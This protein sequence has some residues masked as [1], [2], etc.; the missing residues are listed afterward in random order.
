MISTLLT[1]AAATAI[2]TYI[3][4]ILEKKAG[5]VAP[6]VHKP[7]KP[8]I[9]KT[10]GPA[11]MLSFIIGYIIVCILVKDV[12]NY[13][14][15][16][17][18]AI[19]IGGI[20]GLIDDFTSL[21][22]IVKFALAALPAIPVIIFGAYSPYP[23]VPGIGVLRITL[24]YPVA[25]LLAYSVG[26]NG[27]NMSDTHNGLVP[28]IMG[29]YLMAI[30]MMTVYFSNRSVD[31]F[32]YLYIISAGLVLGYLWFNLYPAKIFNGNA[33]SYMFGTMLVSLA[34]TSRLEFF[35]ILALAPFFL[36]GF[37]ILTSIKG[38]RNKE[39]LR[40]R[41]TVVTDDG[42]IKAN[43]SEEAPITLV[44]LL[45]LKRCLK[46]PELIASYNLLYILSFILAAATYILL[47]TFV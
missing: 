37:N 21:N 8:L 18:A 29:F 16:H 6:D 7:D 30:G 13:V 47:D 19:L 20:I 43:V 26:G 28:T 22:A 1:I 32:P 9:P 25:L 11:L 33:G 41:P 5:L 15:V 4:I 17:V 40:V 31:G 46:E 34:I 3:I 2:L 14:H 45:T 39:L 12:P 35:S 23:Y 38:L 10:A 42:C 27:M 24:V 36:N 44:Q